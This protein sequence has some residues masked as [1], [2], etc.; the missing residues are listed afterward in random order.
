MGKAD[1]LCMCLSDDRAQ[2]MGATKKSLGV[3]GAA[4]SGR[5][6]VQDGRSVAV[7][8]TNDLL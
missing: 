3:T 2:K 5:I 7:V 1:I 6:C 8:Q 4:C